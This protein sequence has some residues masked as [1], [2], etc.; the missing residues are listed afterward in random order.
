MRAGN[1]NI[2]F[3]KSLVDRIKSIRR[4]KLKKKLEFTKEQL[5]KPISFW[6]K[7]DRLLNEIGKEFTIILRTRGCNWALGGTGGCSMCGYVQD[8]NINEVKPSQIINQFNYALQN[9][10]DEIEN[11]KYN[12][13]LKLFNS[14]SFLDEN[15]VAQ[16]VRSYIYNKIAKIKKI[17]EVV[18]ESRIEYVSS[19]KLEELRDS[20]RACFKNIDAAGGL[21]KNK[22]GEI[23]III[24]LPAASILFFLPEQYRGTFW[25]GK[26]CRPFLE[27]ALA[28]LLGLIWI[29]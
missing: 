10:L 28:A 16:N 21:V 18:I 22:K 7:K 8:A 26:A 12:Y 13:V 1:R 9:K 23:L 4:K 5:E 17:K 19:E 25:K 2:K 14:G 24:L 3:N 15:E 6:I 20:F 11:D 29:S 27:A